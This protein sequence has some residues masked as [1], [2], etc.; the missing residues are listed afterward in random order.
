MVNTVEIMN[1]KKTDNKTIDSTLKKQII[2]YDSSGK[3][4]FGMRFMYS[5][6][7]GKLVYSSGIVFLIFCHYNYFTESGAH[8]GD[9]VVTFNDL[10]RDMNFGETWGASHSL[11]QSVTY[12]DDYFLS[13]ALSDA[14]PQGIKV[15]HT[16]KK[17]FLSYYDPVNKKKNSRVIGANSTLAGK[18]TGNQRG[19][20]DGKLGGLLYFEKLGIFCLVYAKTPEP[21]GKNKDKNVIY[22]ATFIFNKNKTY[23]LTKTYEVKVFETDNV[24]QVRAG[25]YG[26]NMLFITYV[27]TP[28]SGSRGSGNV[29]KGSVPKVY[30][31]KL[32][33]FTTVRQDK[34]INT[35]LMNTNEDLRT[36]SDGVLIWATS[37]SD[38]KLVINKIGTPKLNET[39]DDITYKLTKTDVTKYDNTFNNINL[40]QKN[41]SLNAG[42]KLTI[43]LVVLALVFIIVF[44]YCKS[45]KSKAKIDLSTLNG[46]LLYQN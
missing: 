6:D 27:E 8:T 43:A 46:E 18:I 20:A 15:Q 3:P 45:K 25:K 40:N 23:T 22:A 37:N 21:E 34:L 13:A 14:Y 29:V 12:N 1:N 4:V 9:T 26:D 10:L 39:Y 24:M 38:G 41:A 32:P 35:L 44:K 17:D 19:N 7:N 28:Y 11:I 36:F 31:Y 2:K 42:I 16:S 5:P 30:L 33:A